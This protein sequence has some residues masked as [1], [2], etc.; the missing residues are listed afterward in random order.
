MD[1][2]TWSTCR[3]LMLRRDR[4]VT[5]RTPGR[6]RTVAIIT[7]DELFGWNVKLAGLPHVWFG[8]RAAALRWISSVDAQRYICDVRPLRV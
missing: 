5:V 4:A 6:R 1:P 7:R 3:T 2:A 8:E